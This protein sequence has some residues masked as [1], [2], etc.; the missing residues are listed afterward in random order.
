ML[1]MQRKRPRKSE[2]KLRTILK[3]L[4]NKVRREKRR[5]RR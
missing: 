4:T 3:R 2:K 5:T 1:S